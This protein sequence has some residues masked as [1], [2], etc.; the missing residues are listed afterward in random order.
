MSYAE[1]AEYSMKG[2]GKAG[3]P[4]IDDSATGRGKD[5]RVVSNPQ[6]YS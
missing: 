2:T 6:S 1:H 3:D 5:D 4:I